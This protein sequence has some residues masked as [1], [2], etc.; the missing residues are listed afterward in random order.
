MKI[1]LSILIS[2]ESYISKF[3]EAMTLL[4][5]NKIELAVFTHRGSACEAAV[6]NRADIFLVDEEYA[7]CDFKLPKDIELVYFVSGKSVDT[8]N[9]HRAIC[10]YQMVSA[11]Y[12]ELIDIY[13]EKIAATAVT[14]KTADPSG[15]KVITFFAAAGGVG[16]STAA[17]AYAKRLAS[18]EQKV[19]YLNLE[20]IGSSDL[21]F[22]AD[23]Y[24]NFSRVLYALAMDG[25]TTS[26]KIESALK[27]DPSGVYFF[28]ESTSVLDM[29]ELNDE[30]LEQLF[31]NLGAISLF[32]WIIVDADFS[33][34]EITYRQM[35]RS[36]LTIF[37]SSG[38]ESS[39]RKLARILDGLEVIASQREQ[40]QLN[41]IVLLYNRFSSK[42]STILKQNAFKELGIINR[43]ENASVQEMVQLIS[44][45]HIFDEI[46]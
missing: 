43:V 12:K 41:R 42:N 40:F 30:R 36:Y 29:H 27:Q 1:K 19:L 25:N 26:M 11:I 8:V 17:V 45:N 4:Y 32:D 35:E 34:Q 18:M 7:E 6:K 23:G 20:E 9:G 37:V 10:K 44:Q 38:S 21:Y 24:D 5:A 22:S 28:S 33:F 31:L 15:Q 2:D 14:L 16:A 46:V 3:S 13:A 39:N